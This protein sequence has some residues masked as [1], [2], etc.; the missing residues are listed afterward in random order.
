[1]TTPI[2]HQAGT[3]RQASQLIVDVTGAVDREMKAIDAIHLDL[4]R[5]DFS[6][7]SAAAFQFVMDEM[8]QSH[9][10]INKHLTAVAQLVTEAGDALVFVEEEQE[11][12]MK[13]T[14]KSYNI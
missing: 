7:K 14:I 2:G 11:Q 5:K 3:T 1:V 9:G 4:V 13:A 8:K 6:G 12:R 10:E